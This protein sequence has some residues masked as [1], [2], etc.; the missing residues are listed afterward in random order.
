M[1][2]GTQALFATQQQPTHSFIQQA[3]KPEPPPPQIPQLIANA[4][5]QIVAIG[6]PSQVSTNGSPKK[7]HFNQFSI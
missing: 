3:V 2:S 4:Q 7:M 5:G 1:A 6:T